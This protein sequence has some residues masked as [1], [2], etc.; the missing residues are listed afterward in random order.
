MAEA[1]H[2]RKTRQSRNFYITIQP[3]GQIK[4]R[5]DTEGKRG[6]SISTLNIFSI[7]AD[8]LS[9]KAPK[10]KPSNRVKHESSLVDDLATLLDQVMFA[11]FILRSCSEVC[12]T[13]FLE[14]RSLGIGR[15][16]VREYSRINTKLWLAMTLTPVS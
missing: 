15:G 4:E 9:Q 5:D 13:N 11:L 10:I 3:R 16:R 6:V 12:N 1:N 14:T 2:P 7:V 8:N